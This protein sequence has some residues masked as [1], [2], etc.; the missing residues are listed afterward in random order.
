MKEKKR[1]K[2]IYPRHR[3]V[4]NLLRMVLG[5][6]S[7]LTF[8]VEVEKFAQQGD[9]QYLIM[10]NHQTSFDQFFIGMAFHGPIYFIATEDIFIKDIS[11]SFSCFF[12]AAFLLCSHQYSASQSE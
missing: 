5:P 8:G 12:I 2:W 7:R 6:Y 9:R 11:D 10:M 1:K 3:V 4:Q